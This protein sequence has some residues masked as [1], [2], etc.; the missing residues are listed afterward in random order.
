MIL[1]IFSVIY[2]DR[3]YQV[4]YLGHEQASHK[5]LSDTETAYNTPLALGCGWEIKF[6]G[7]KRVGGGGRWVAGLNEIMTN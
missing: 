2:D 7:S 1:E 3:M 4:F 6:P 5:L